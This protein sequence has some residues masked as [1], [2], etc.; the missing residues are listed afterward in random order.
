LLFVSDHFIDFLI[1]LFYL[2]ILHINYIFATF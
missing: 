2:V 1:H